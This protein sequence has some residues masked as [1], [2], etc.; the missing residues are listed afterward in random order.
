[1][2]SSVTV[3]LYFVSLLEKERRDPTAITAAEEK[4]WAGLKVLLGLHCFIF[5]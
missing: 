2:N 5:F 1:V 3:K 4:D